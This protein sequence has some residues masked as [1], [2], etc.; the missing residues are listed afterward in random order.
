MNKPHSYS[1]HV[2]S[3]HRP[4]DT[5]RE[6]CYN[7]ADGRVERR[8]GR[9]EMVIQI[10]RTRFGYTYAAVAHVGELGMLDRAMLFLGFQDAY[11]THFAHE[12]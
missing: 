7:R 12:M 10:Q 2:D 5:A 3:R 8:H 1:H 4:L 9:H 11:Y 6:L